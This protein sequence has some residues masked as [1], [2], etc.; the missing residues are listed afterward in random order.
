MSILARIRAHG[1]DVVRQDWRL[2]LQPGR[3]SAEALAWVR[4]K[5]REVCA[6]AWPDFDRWDERAAIMEHDGK[7][8]RESAERTAY[9]GLALC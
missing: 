5:W 8:T 3:M 4:T 2:R 6:E 9:E 1:G 7:M